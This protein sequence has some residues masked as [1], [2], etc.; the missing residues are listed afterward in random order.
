[1]S[2]ILRMWKNFRPLRYPGGVVRSLT[3]CYRHTD[4]GGAIAALKSI[5]LSLF[6]NENNVEAVLDTMIETSKLVPLPWGRANPKKHMIGSVR[7]L[8]RRAEF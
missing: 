1:M 8:L 5:I 6:G 3:D 4:C 7:G 2:V